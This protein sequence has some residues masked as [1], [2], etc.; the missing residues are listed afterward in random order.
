MHFAYSQG[1]KRL[2]A[3]LFCACGFNSGLRN[4]HQHP[5]RVGHQQLKTELQQTRLRN[6]Q[7][8]T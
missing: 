2:I 1:S 8:H 4:V 7:R 3:R 5:Q 6:V